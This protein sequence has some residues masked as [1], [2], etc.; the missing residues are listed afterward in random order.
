MMNTL[1]QCDSVWG[2]TVLLLE[3]MKQQSEQLHLMTVTV[4]ADQRHSPEAEGQET[5]RKMMSS[6]LAAVDYFRNVRK[7]L[8]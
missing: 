4:G 7:A 6:Q 8:C 5:K 2:F 1:R 3:K